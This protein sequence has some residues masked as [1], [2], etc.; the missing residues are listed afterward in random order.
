MLDGTVV[1]VA[2]P[3]DRRGPRRS[4]GAAA[5]DH[6]RLPALAGQ[7][8]PARRLARRPLRSPAGLRDRHGLVRRRR[9]CCAAWRPTRAAD[10]GPHPAGRRRRAAHAGQ[11]GDDPGRLRPRRPGARRSA[12]WS[13]LG[14]IAAAIG[15]FVGGCAGRVR[16]LALDLP[17][18]PADRRGHRGGRACGTC[19]RPPTR[20]RRAAS[21]SPARCSRRSSSAGSPTR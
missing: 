16:Q 13:G 17:D 14:G 8:D 9:R 1:N 5:V 15:P 2:L 3:H 20:T 10:R 11:P 19:R 4:P 18:Q 6:Q 7:P 12:S 21:T